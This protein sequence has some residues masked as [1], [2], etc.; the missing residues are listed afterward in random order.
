M[1]RWESD[2]RYYK[3][4]IQ[5]DLFGLCVVYRYGGLGT[6]Q[7]RSRSIPCDDIDHAKRELR[8][9]FKR[10]KQRGYRLFP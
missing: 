9:I 10:R 7:G 5:R 8:A 4:T 3:A 1:I 6:K 2:T